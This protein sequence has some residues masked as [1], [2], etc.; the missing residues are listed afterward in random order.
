L[1]VIALSSQLETLV[2]IFR[3]GFPLQDGEETPGTRRL[4]FGLGYPLGRGVFPAGLFAA[5]VV[6][7]AV[8]GGGPGEVTLSLEEPAE[9]EIGHGVI[10]LEPDRLTLRRDLL[11][12]LPLRLQGTDE[13]GVGFGVVVG[14]QPDRLLVEG[15]GLVEL[16]LVPQGVG[17]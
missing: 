15:D 17:L 13:A 10:G 11:A 6:S 3:S 2:V 4:P 7:V 5:Q 14:S 12:Q 8:L 1:L 16:I 9:V